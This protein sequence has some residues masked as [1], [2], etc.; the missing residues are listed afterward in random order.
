MKQFIVADIVIE[1]FD[2]Y[3]IIF[4]VIACRA[5]PDAHKIVYRW[6]SC[7][8]TMEEDLGCIRE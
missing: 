1:L 6:F 4:F 7:N 5:G 8:S 2:R 3:N